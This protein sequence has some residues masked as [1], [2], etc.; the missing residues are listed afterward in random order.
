MSQQYE[1]V[2]GHEQ[3]QAEMHIERRKKR[4]RFWPSSFPTG[5]RFGILSCAL[6]ASISFLVNLVITIVVVARYGVDSDGQLQ[7]YEGN[8]KIVERSNTA[9][10]IYINLMGT[11][12]LGSS[13]YAMQ[14]LSSATRKDV[15]KAHGAKKPR[16]LDVG[17]LSLSNLLYIDWK[18]VLLWV[19]LGLSSLPL[20]LLYVNSW[21]RN[22]IH[23]NHLVA[24][25]LPSSPRL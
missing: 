17:V 3:P 16:W 6:A 13:S 10:H 15:D 20:H 12:L 21:E 23:S 19:I 25:I 18:R 1:L 5:W 24:I 8:C 9:A 7:L 22:E 4:R 11:I 2:A 14:C